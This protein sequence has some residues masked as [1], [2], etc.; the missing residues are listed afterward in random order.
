MCFMSFWHLLPSL[1]A[2]VLLLSNSALGYVNYG[3][4]NRDEYNRF[5]RE[6]K[7][8][9]RDGIPSSR[10]DFPLVT[11]YLPSPPPQATPVEVPSLLRAREKEGLSDWSGAAFDL[12][13]HLGTAPWDVEAH[14]RRARALAHLNRRTEAVQLYLT[15]L[16]MAPDAQREFRDPLRRQRWLQAVEKGN[17]HQ[18]LTESALV[19]PDPNASIEDQEGLL[20]VQ[21]AVGRYQDVARTVK[22]LTD[23]IGLID[24]AESQDALLLAALTAPLDARTARPLIEL[25][26]HRFKQA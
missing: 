6:H 26:R 2:G 8:N 9:A 3:F 11:S 22:F 1:C 21:R 15:T 19:L 5:L 13:E 4:R 7:L 17:W 23:R 14:L 20:L 16:I 24:R 12:G 18:A 25:A 10:S